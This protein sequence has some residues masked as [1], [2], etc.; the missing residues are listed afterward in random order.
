MSR[1]GRNFPIQKFGAL[2]GLD[3]IANNPHAAKNIPNKEDKRNEV[4]LEHTNHFT[5]RVPF[6]IQQPAND[7]TA[8]QHAIQHDIEDIDDAEEFLYVEEAEGEVM[9]CF[10]LPMNWEQQHKLLSFS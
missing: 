7:F 8:L 5:N 3:H 10:D 6:N 2:G 1:T 4:R 9:R